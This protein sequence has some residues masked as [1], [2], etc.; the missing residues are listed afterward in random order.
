MGSYNKIITPAGQ[1][2]MHIRASPLIRFLSD[3][4]LSELHDRHFGWTLE[5]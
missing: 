2:T 1:W 5:T 4:V 3:Q